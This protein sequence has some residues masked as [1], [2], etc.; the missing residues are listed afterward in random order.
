MLYLGRPLNSVIVEAYRHIVDPIEDP[1]ERIALAR[2]VAP[3][4]LVTANVIASNILDLRDPQT[5]AKLQLTTATLTCATD[6]RDGYAACQRVAQV[7]HQ[8]GLHGLITPAATKLGHT[9]ALFTDQLP[10]AER[11][12]RDEPDVVWTGLPPDPRHTSLRRQGLVTENDPP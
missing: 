8:L 10:A 12:T 5:R 11:P 3:R 7:A 9:L 6:D 4:V 1:A 2:N